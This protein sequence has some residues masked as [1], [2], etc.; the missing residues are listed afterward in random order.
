MSRTLLITWSLGLAILDFKP[1][2][3]PGYI[4]ESTFKVLSIIYFLELHR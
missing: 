1:E 3:L 4:Q 2:L